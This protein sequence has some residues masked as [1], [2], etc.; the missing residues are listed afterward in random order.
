M[1]AWA[2]EWEART[3][4]ARSISRARVPPV[5]MSMPRNMELLVGYAMVSLR[6]PGLRAKCQGPSKA[7]PVDFGARILN[8][9]GW[10][11]HL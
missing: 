9:W 1:S 2:A 10:K 4:P 7:V 5:P 8:T 6:L 11:L 3:E